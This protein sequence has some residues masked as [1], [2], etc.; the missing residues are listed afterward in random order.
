ML[1]TNREAIQR[2]IDDLKITT[3]NLTLNGIDQVPPVKVVSGNFNYSVNLTEGTNTITVR[4]TNA[5]GTGISSTLTIKLN[6]QAP[7]I[8]ITS[9]QQRQITNK[10][11]QKIKI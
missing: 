8:A 5:A 1:T 7:V 2:T 6:S 10:S 4:A 11:S 3:A 9:H